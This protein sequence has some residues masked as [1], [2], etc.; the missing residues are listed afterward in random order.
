MTEL[1]YEA[2]GRE[3]LDEVAPL[4]NKLLDHHLQLATHFAAEIAQINFEMRRGTFLEKAEEGDLRVDVVRAGP[5]GTIVGYCVTTIDRKRTGEIE[6]IFVEEDYRGSGI[7]ERLM[8]L[9]LA[10]LEDVGAERRILYV[11]SGNEAVCPFY[12]RFGFFPQGTLLRQ[13]GSD[14]S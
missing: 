14:S 11:A 6:S 3:L 8:R 12:E 4:W 13:K 1:T 7:G 10:W 9:A 5:A 2:G